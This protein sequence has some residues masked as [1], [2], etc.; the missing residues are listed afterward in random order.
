MHPRT[1]AICCVLGLL[2][3]ALAFIVF[4]AALAAADDLA[5]CRAACVEAR[6]DPKTSQMN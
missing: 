6:L 5:D 3:W 2:V 1:L 4:A